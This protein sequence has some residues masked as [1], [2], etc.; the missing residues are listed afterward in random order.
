LIRGD[1]RR[2]SRVVRL[3]GPPDGDAAPASRLARTVVGVVTGGFFFGGF[4]GLVQS[5]TLAFS[6]KCV[7][8]VLLV[9]LVVLHVHNCVR[10]PDGRRPPGWAWT[11]AAQALLTYLPMVW[12]HETWYG[13]PGFLAGAFLVLLRPAWLAWTGFAVVLAVHVEVGLAVRPTLVEALYLVA[14]QAA[15]VGLAVYAI[16]RLADLVAALSATRTALAEAGVARERLRFG[17][18]LTAGV[19]ATLTRIVGRGDALLAGLRERPNSAR[20]QLEETLE[21]ARG[22]M[23]QARAFA[24]T[25][26]NAEQTPPPV[27]DEPTPRAVA[28][29]RVVI[30]TLL[31][32]PLPIRVLATGRHSTGEWVLF[33][34]LLLAFLALFVRNCTPADGDRPRWWPWTLAAQVALAYLPLVV[35]DLRTWTVGL[36]L[37]GLALVLLRGPWRWLVATALAVQDLPFGTWSGTTLD[38]VYNIVWVAERAALVYGLVRM[39]EIARELTR[40]RAELIATHVARERLRFGRDLHDLL[41]FSLSA[42]VLKSQLALRFVDRDVEVAHAQLAEGLVMAR[43]AL[44]D[45]DTVAGG[46]RGMSLAVEAPTAHGILSAAGLVVEL[47]V[48][49]GVLS[50]DADTVLATVLR[51]GTT[52]VLRHSSAR[53]CAISAYVEADGDVVLTLINDGVRCAPAPGSGAEPGMGLASL[54]GRLTALGGTLTTEVVGGEFRLHARIPGRRPSAHV[55]LPGPGPVVRAREHGTS[56]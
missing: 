6:T 39:A 2:V 37:P 8:F 28:V 11:L 42:L 18:T 54:L 48:D 20:A 29:L 55:R 41:G 53:R 46:Y 21:Q 30:L 35:F 27:V 32:V 13:N 10:R 49:V 44:T 36:Y 16:A 43:Q 9:A 45:V 38:T 22:A 50:S 52:N 51:E 23:N 24:H 5:A 40:A 25:H 7:A 26:R 17:E 4:V 14:G 56:A 19:G 15:L 12:L 34:V 47:T 3:P 31:I 1:R 33:A